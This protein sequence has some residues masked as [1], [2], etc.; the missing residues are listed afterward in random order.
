MKGSKLYQPFGWKILS[1][2]A[3]PKLGKTVIFTMIWGSAISII[4]LNGTFSVTLSR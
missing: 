3:T 4:V 2:M 1:K